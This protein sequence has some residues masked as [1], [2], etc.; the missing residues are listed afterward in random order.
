MILREIQK[1]NNEEILEEHGLKVKRKRR[2][3]LVMKE[4]KEIVGNNCMN[5]FPATA[6]AAAKPKIGCAG[7]GGPR[8]TTNLAIRLFRYCG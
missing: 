7:S 3:K 4:S 5:V 8:N 6:S 2:L 1:E